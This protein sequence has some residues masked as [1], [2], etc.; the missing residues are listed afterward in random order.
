[1]IKRLTIVLALVAA[2]LAA[3]QTANVRPGD[4]VR[5]RPGPSGV[6]R[7]EEAR[8]GAVLARR[9]GREPVLV[10]ADSA[11]MLR[12]AGRE[13]RLR[14]AGR[15]LL[16]GA[17]I[18]GAGGAVLGAASFDEPDYVAGTPSAAAALGGVWFGVLGAAT[19]GVIGALTPRTR[20]T[21]VRSAAR[22]TAA[23][24]QPTVRDGGVG[25]TLTVRF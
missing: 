19:G 20:W 14:S 2:P 11:R 12:A 18:G 5:F 7:V 22:G 17:L 15:G 1:M 6:Y 23:V 13:P 21:P 16:I 8:P 25:A 3:Q 24:V 10:S 4:L 9:E